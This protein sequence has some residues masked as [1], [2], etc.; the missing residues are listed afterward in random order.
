MNPEYLFLH[1]IIFRNIPDWEK[2]LNE[3]LNPRCPPLKVA[4]TRNRF[5]KNGVNFLLKG[6]V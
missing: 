6:D 2:A 5:I 4:L 1:G 3:G